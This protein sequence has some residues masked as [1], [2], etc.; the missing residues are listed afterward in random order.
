[1]TNSKYLAGAAALALVAAA[2]SGGSSPEATITT[3]TSATT[4]VSETTTTSTAPSSTTST[5][6]V[7]STT[8]APDVARQPLTGVPVES[9]ADIT[10]RAAL[11]VKIDNQAA[12][13]RNHSG[14]AVA[15]LV[16][17]EKVEGGVT[18]F[19]AVFHSQ[20]ADPVGPI[21][22]G[23]EQDVNLLSSL[24][25]PLFG[26]SGGNPGVTR[27][28]RASFLVDVG[29][30]LNFGSYYRGPGSAPHNLYSDTASLYALTPEDHPGAPPRQFEFLDDGKVFSGD[31]A[32]KVSFR[33][34]SID[35]MWDWNADEGRYERSQEGSKHVDKTYGQ[36][37]AQ[38]VIVLAVDYRQS[39]IDS[40]A[41]EAVTLGGGQATVFSNGEVIT[42]RWQKD[43]A[44]YNFVL[45]DNNGDP[46]KLTPGQTWI[47]LVEVG[48]SGDP[49][50]LT[51][52]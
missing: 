15:D 48:T 29:A 44:I 16:F 12:A 35:I 37:G 5:I 3:V 19:A 33:I 36:I 27:L 38:N 45:T 14:L 49:A 6:S 20:D 8:L 26:W 32:K 46:I 43:L 42:G 21:R 24:N 31:A 18:R 13:R 52:E 17:E 41:P 11:A 50:D 9:E 28:V 30:P 25:E 22:S 51:I 34:G 7:P 10:D 47:E 23:R 40:Q 4:A 39:S 2:C 1:M